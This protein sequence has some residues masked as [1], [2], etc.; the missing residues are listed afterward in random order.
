MLAKWMKLGIGGTEFKSH[1]TQSVH[2]LNNGLG[3]YQITT[4]QLL[5]PVT[6]YI[7][8]VVPR[9]LIQPGP[10]PRR[11]IVHL[12]SLKIYTR[13]SLSMGTHP[14]LSMLF[15]FFYV[16]LFFSIFFYGVA[17]PMSNPFSIRNFP[18]VRMSDEYV[19]NAQYPLPFMVTWLHRCTNYSSVKVNA[20]NSIFFNA[21]YEVEWTLTAKH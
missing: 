15:F 14:Q 20:M 17:I 10:L 2:L 3:K 21:G 19:R 7:L 12:K 13:H 9:K 16:A 8:P 1:L 18:S 5:G 6:E 4:F 11:W